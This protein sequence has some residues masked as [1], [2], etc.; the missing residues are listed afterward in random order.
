MGQWAG[1]AA[2]GASWASAGLAASLSSAEMGHQLQLV[3][4]K[5]LGVAMTAQNPR[6][7]RR[8]LR[9]R[10]ALS[11]PASHGLAEPAPLL[12]SLPPLSVNVISHWASEGGSEG[13][14]GGPSLLLPLARPWPV[15]DKPP[16]LSVAFRGRVPGA[17]G[18]RAMPPRWL[19]SGQFPAD[20]STIV[21]AFCL[22][23][24]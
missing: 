10:L 3:G 1:L 6:A 22:S 23:I 17:V 5:L 24:C 11:R 9:R 21:N 2:L 16:V 13:I 7:E 15:L 19:L 20:D 18:K 12:R 14:P 8:R 4:V